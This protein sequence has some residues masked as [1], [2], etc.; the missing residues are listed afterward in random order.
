MEEPG[1]HCRRGT[2]P[3]NSVTAHQWQ[4]RPRLARIAP[5]FGRLR[6]GAALPSSRSIGGG[7]AG[8]GERRDSEARFVGG[9]RGQ[10]KKISDLKVGEE[11]GWMVVGLV[12]KKTSER[13]GLCNSFAS[14]RL[15]E[16][17]DGDGYGIHLS[18]LRAIEVY[19]GPFLLLYE[20]QVGLG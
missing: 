18:G 13:R 12:R 19:T 3:R 20:F 17:D 6:A 2:C 11:F 4:S 15:C 10:K 9:G 7:E 1:R 14:H 16:S 5:K 8:G